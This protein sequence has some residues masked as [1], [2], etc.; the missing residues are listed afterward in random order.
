[1][2]IHEYQARNLF[3]AYGIPTP[4]GDV[5]QTPDEALL[6]ACKIG[7]PVVMKAQVLVGGRGKAGGV[8]VVDN[9]A[10][11]MLEFNRIRNLNI[12]GY[13]VDHLLVARAIDI[14]QE[15]YL[16]VTIDNIMG[17]VVII[18]SAEGGI[19]IEETAKAQPEKIIKLYMQ[20]NK[21]LDENR[22]ASV[23]A[24]LF[25]NSGWQARATDKRTWYERSTAIVQK[26]LKLFF[27][28][29]CSLVE[30]NPLC[31]SGEG[32]WLA[33]DAKI[34]IDDNGLLRHAELGLLRDLKYED[35]DELEARAK[36]LSFVKLEGH[37]G[38]IV[39]GAGL[40]M[41]TMD[42]VNLMGAKPAN[43]LDVGGSSN[44]QKMIYAINILLRNKDI[45][46]ILVNIFGGITRCD[47]IA[48]GILTA[49][50][51]IDIPVPL[52]IRLTGTN[53]ALAHALLSQAGVMTF[54]SMR[55]AVTQ[56]VK[57]AQ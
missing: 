10:D 33:A 30:I 28:N 2:K 12:K 5:A 9:E 16:A 39:N 56:A 25:A 50:K 7:F 38:C 32:Q 4:E 8:K 43:F 42:V 35:A 26:L 34:I 17:D 52:V 37:V 36:G 49:L 11:L 21:T 23:A 47:D 31:F 57:A 6:I 1:M 20:G 53:E 46:V 48:N 15:Y 45:K 41:A 13:S 24:Q 18:A 14:K 27:E 55:Q 3:A 51:Q 19:E 44:P 29:D 22:W 40:A 54:T